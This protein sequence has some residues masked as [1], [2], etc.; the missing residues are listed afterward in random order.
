MGILRVYQGAL[1]HYITS[2]AKKKSP[3][4]EKNRKKLEKIS[5]KGLTNGKVCDIIAK[6]SR[7]DDPRGHRSLKIEQ[8]NFENK[9][10]VKT[11]V[12][13]RNLVKKHIE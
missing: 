10:F 9:T 6:L 1:Y 12:C 11:K 13:V 2:F 4:A 3:H 8:Q 7:R 5:K